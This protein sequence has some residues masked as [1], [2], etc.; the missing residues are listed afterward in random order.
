MD[1]VFYLLKSSA[2]LGLFLLV[3]ELLLKRET[4]FTVNRL[5]LLAGV[6]VAALLPAITYVKPIFSDPVGSMTPFLALPSLESASLSITRNVSD[7]NSSLWHHILS[8]HAFL[9]LYG[10]GVLVFLGKFC[11]RLYKLQRLLARQSIRYTTHNIQFI[12]TTQHTNPFS[13]F[14]TVVFNPHLHPE[15]ELQLILS[16]EK[17]HVEQHHSWD[18]MIAHIVVCLNWFNPLAWLY[19]K[20]ITQNLEFLADNATTAHL[21]SKKYYQMSL[22]R[23]AT[24]A[25]ID[26]PVNHFHSF[27]KTRILMLHKTTSSKTAYLKIGV[28]LPLLL[29]FFMGFQIKTVAQT[30]PKSATQHQVQNDQNIDNA[31]L[32]E[33]FKDLTADDVI[34]INDKVIKTTALPDAFYKINALTINDNEEPVIKGKLLVFDEYA[35][36]SE[37]WNGY[38]VKFKDN[39]II[40][41]TGVDGAISAINVFKPELGNKNTRLVS[42]SVTYS[43]SSTNSS[44]SAHNTNTTNQSND[45][46]TVTVSISIDKNSPNKLLDT[47]K[48]LLKDKGISFSYNGLKRNKAGEITQLT[49]KLD[50]HKGHSSKTSYAY[51]EGIPPLKISYS[52]MGNKFFVISEQPKD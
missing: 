20:R 17:A 6:I 9:Y 44:K 27:T 3:Y 2:L 15:K 23:V 48:Q 10:L 31:L 41:I 13:F 14:K 33:A 21:H 12:E 38:Y 46:R 28:I 39:G 4:F 51:S 47:I 26:L 35:S 19:R 32:N 5:F 7:A 50:N 37:G 43:Q 40:I 36:P 42:N 29:V 18:V 11:F 45:N 24:A 49:L 52:D 25:P 34:I 16:H 22:L 1:S 8:T 30:A